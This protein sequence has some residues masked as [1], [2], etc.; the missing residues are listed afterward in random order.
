MD[1]ERLIVSLEARIRDFERNMV[2]AER[3][4][5]KTYQGLQRGSKRATTRMER[6]MRRSTQ[7]INQA[8][9]T[10]TTRVG[11]FSKAFAAGAITAGFAA[12][13]T[14]A[15][16]AVRSIAEIDR[17]AKRAGLS[18]ETFQELAF[19]SQQNQIGIDN[20][21]DGFKELSLRADEFIVTGAGPA[22]EAFQRLGFDAEDL[23]RR[24]E[25]P[26]ELF[27]EIVDRLEDLDRAAQIRI[28]DEVFGGTGGERFVE[29][30]AQGDDG[31][32]QMMDRANEL[33]VVMDEEA[34]AKAAELDRKFA[35][36]T[37]RVSTLAKTIVVDLAGAI[38]DVAS[39]DVDDLFGSTERAIAML[40]QEN[41]DAFKRM[42]DVSEKHKDT[43]ED[44]LST[45]EELFQAINRA[46]GPSGLRL[47]DVADVD[48][49][50]DIAA[51]LQEIDGNMR[52]FENGSIQVEEFEGSIGE[53]VA[54][55][56]ELLKELSDV[57]AQRFTNV[58]E[59][60][61]AIA[62]ALANASSQASTL[63]AELPEGT[64]VALSRGR[65]P[66][67][68][69]PSNLRNPPVEEPG[70]TRSSTTRGGGG[71]GSAF[72]RELEATRERIR[73]LEAETTA[74]IAASQGGRRFGDALEFARKKAE[75]L[76]AAQQEGKEITPELAAEI[77]RLAEAYTRAGEE[78]DSAADEMTE[79]EERAERGAERLTDVFMSI[80]DGSEDAK[81][82]L[83]RLLQEIARAQIEQGISGLVG[84]F[85]GGGILGSLLSFD[86]GG[87]TGAGSRTGG[88]DGRGGFPAILHPNETVIDHTKA[89]PSV[90]R[91]GDVN[92]QHVWKISAN[93]DDSV[94]RIVR[95]EAPRI[96]D[97]SVAAVAERNR[98]DP[99]YLGR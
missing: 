65:P 53:A 10:T 76:V 59:Q 2:K 21:V 52:A 26:S 42:D 27:L 25:D 40:G 36:V 19:V 34:I 11:Q 35:E 72:D 1:E 4:G 83:S 38:E 6:D 49:A 81:D 84:A 67:R 24:L 37:A 23:K 47:M 85:G 8:L 63:R 56:Q 55:A 29:L 96:A 41:Y 31:I 15:R 33:G 16:R 89:A 80:I 71:G 14:G 44:L 95:E 13:S 48:I 57:D 98:R 22:A 46:T 54:E 3:R 91:G 87:Y 82:A 93:G 32:R 97:L 28:A 69:L 43:I 77:D 88:V 12:M 51:I 79:L 75:L 68:R 99:N 78:A 74:L 30:L 18:I 17:Q 60:I 5:T 64:G 92:V 66:I 39:I 70:R 62:T 94:R 61:G 90:V 45:Y 7:R 58:A 50:Q 73:L 86:G 9:A 20:L